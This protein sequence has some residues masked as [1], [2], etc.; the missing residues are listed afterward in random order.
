VGTL[1]PLLRDEK[2]IYLARVVDRIPESLRPLDQVTE[3][4]R[5]RLVYEEKRKT[6][7]RE[8]KAFYRKALATTFADALQVYG[9]T[10]KATAA[11]KASE[12]V[13]NFGAKSTVAQA[14]LSTAKG[15]V[16]PPVMSRRSFVVFRLVDKSESDPA[17]FRLKAPQIR[18]Q[19]EM[20]KI[21]S[22]TAYWFEKIKKESAVEDYRD[23]VS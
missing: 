7:E 17:D 12:S 14:A 16:A 15:A 21:Q 6:A 2:H 18:E 9:R 19:L 22:Y 1:S 8:A 10:A 3:S 23:R 5:H 13:E 20:Q 4:I 11:F